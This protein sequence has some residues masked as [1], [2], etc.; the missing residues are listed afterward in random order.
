[1]YTT[2]KKGH[3]NYTQFLSQLVYITHISMSPINSRNNLINA[4]HNGAILCMCV[5]VRVLVG[6]TNLIRLYIFFPRAPLNHIPLNG[7]HKFPACF[8]IAFCNIVTREKKN[9][10]EQIIIKA[11]ATAASTVF[12]AS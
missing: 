2:D 10:T 9:G 5:C 6:V 4:L 11:T 8:P 1:M 7:I 3:S 12:T